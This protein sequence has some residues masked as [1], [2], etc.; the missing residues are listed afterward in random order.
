MI[1]DTGTIKA[2]LLI[3]NSCFLSLDGI[4]RIML[5]HPKA[6]DKNKLQ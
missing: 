6:F 5:D 4:P 3:L 1:S 2:S